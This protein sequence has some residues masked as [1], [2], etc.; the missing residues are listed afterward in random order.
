MTALLYEYSVVMQ[1]YIQQVNDLAVKV[2][3]FRL[4]VP[5][6]GEHM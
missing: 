3:V 1:V 2:R 4:Q 5:D 6:Y